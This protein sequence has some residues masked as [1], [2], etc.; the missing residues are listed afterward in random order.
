MEGEAAHSP[1]FAIWCGA[2]D[3][4]VLVVQARH[5]AEGDPDALDLYQL[6][7]GVTVLRESSGRG[8]V[9]HVAI[10]DGPRRLRLELRGDSPLDGPVALRFGLSGFLGLG[11][12][13]LALERMSA[14]WRLGRLPHR[15]YPPDNVVAR[16]VMALHAWDAAQSGASQREIARLVF[17]DAVMEGLRYGDARLDALRKRVARMI[18]QAERRIEAGGRRFLGG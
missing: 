17:G 16:W 8:R 7:M 12:H 13:I 4:G 5:V 10:A 1:P 15:L 3:P 14:L 11:Q 9:E 2:A 6:G 18:R